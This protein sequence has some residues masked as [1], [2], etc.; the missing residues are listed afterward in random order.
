LLNLENYAYNPRLQR[1]VIEDRLKYLTHL[2][3]QL[4]NLY[5]I[6]ANRLFFAPPSLALRNL[7]MQERST[8]QGY[9]A[10]YNK[11]IA[12]DVSSYN[13]SASALRV[14]YYLNVHELELPPEI[15]VSDV[16]N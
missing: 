15:H 12:T 10:R 3:G 2:H 16:Q 11:L 1:N 8:L 6:T 14:P 13:R 9:I 5:N 7:M 4:Q